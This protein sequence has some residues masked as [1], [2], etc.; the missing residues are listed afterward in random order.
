MRTRPWTNTRLWYQNRTHLS[1]ER[2]VNNKRFRSNKNRITYSQLFFQCSGNYCNCLDTLILLLGELEYG[3]FPFPGFWTY[4]TF[5]IFV[6]CVLLVMMNLLTGMALM[7]VQEL[8]NRSLPD[9]L[10]F[11]C[12]FSVLLP[13]ILL[14]GVKWMQS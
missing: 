14:E 2:G 4:I 5:S 10:F 8:N 13:Y 9:V 3:D 7:D 12:P 11:P 1:S 6:F